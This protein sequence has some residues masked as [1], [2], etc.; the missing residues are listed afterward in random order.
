MVVQDKI[1]R[2]A[3]ASIAATIPQLIFQAVSVVIGLSQYYGFE[4]SAGVYLPADLTKTFW[5]AVFGV[6]IW[7][8][9]STILGITTCYIIHWTGR[10]YSWLKGM[11]VANTIM[12]IAI[13]GYFYALGGPSIA[14]SDLGTNWSML[15]AN[16]IF[17][18]ACGWL[19]VRWS[20][21]EE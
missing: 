11:L 13:Y 5:G 1:A 17:G 20:P 21:K 2:G 12:F 4:L 6:L 16:T 15:I 7:E 10:S 19:I 8:F 18:V 14:P 3:L 9:A